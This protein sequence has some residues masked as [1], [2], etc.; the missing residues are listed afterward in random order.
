MTQLTNAIK[1]HLDFLA[2]EY[3]WREG[4]IVSPGKFEGE[5][6]ATLYYYDALMCGDQPDREEQDWVFFTIRKD[7]GEALG[8][9]GEYGIKESDDGFVFGVNLGA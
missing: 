5:T 1:D 8:I 3:D 4:Q 9:T 6:L 2:S 7:E